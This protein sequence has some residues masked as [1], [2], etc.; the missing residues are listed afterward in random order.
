MA[1][2]RVDLVLGNSQFLQGISQAD[3]AQRRFAGSWEANVGRVFRRSPFARAE[4]A[5]GEFAANLSAGNIGGAVTALG[6]RITGFG[7][8]AALAFT[9][10]A[11]SFKKLIDGAKEA[12]SVFRTVNAEVGK[13][14]P[15]GEGLGPA[16]EKD[17]KLLEAL[18]G[19]RS[20]LIGS[21]ALG[22]NAGPGLTPAQER[23]MRRFGFTSDDLKS[24]AG[25]KS[26]GQQAEEG[27]QERIAELIH[28]R[29]EYEDRIAEAKT[30]SLNGDKLGAQ[31][32]QN[33]LSLEEARAKLMDRAATEGRLNAFAQLP[34]FLDLQRGLGRAGGVKSAQDL[35]AHRDFF[36]DS[37]KGF[38]PQSAA[39]TEGFLREKI[40]SLRGN[41]TDF[42]LSSNPTLA[43]RVGAMQLQ[44]DQLQ[45]FRE[46]ARL[47]ELHNIS[48]NSIMNGP[49]G[50]VFDANLDNQIQAQQDKVNQLSA[51]VLKE[52]IESSN[53]PVV[54]GLGLIVQTMD[55]YWK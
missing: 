4:R 35:S 6:S 12:G 53:D 15:V 9:A 11:A 19:R 41:A 33:Q 30:K 37:I 36:Q 5:L 34:I 49:G 1:E 31:L 14:F 24:M 50:R 26:P 22:P 27:L 32:L 28:K 48:D 46:N 38:N 40:A 10:A 52:Q 20:T 17:I 45:L 44:A 55:K 16:V 43:R 42:E 47:T 39:V 7:I 51:K 3:A 13:P 8:G 54:R 21:I 23:E 29:A 2:A 25:N 18:Q